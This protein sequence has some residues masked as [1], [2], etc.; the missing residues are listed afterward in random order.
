ML[1][2]RETLATSI[3]STLPA[4][5]E[6]MKRYL[7]ILVFLSFTLLLCAQP[8]TDVRTSQDIRYQGNVVTNSA[9]ET[10]V[11]WEENAGSGYQIQAQKY[12]TLGNAAFDSPVI[13]STGIY[14]VFLVETVATSDGGVV[15]LYIQDIEQQVIM[16]VQKLNSLGQAQWTGNGTFVA[17]AMSPST[18]LAPPEAKLCA[19]NLGGAF[20]V[21]WGRDDL[22][23]F[24]LHGMNY[25][26]S[27]NNIWTE[28]NLFLNPV[29]FKVNQLLLTDAGDL[30]INSAHMQGSFFRKVNNSGLSIGNDPM[31]AADA[32]I[33]AHPRQPRMQK[34]NSG[35]ILIYSSVFHEGNPLEMQLMDASGN[36]VY[37]SLKQLPVGLIDENIGELKIAA[38]S[39]GGFIL[40]CLT[41][42]NLHEASELRVQRLDAN[43]EPVW[44]SENP[45]I[46]SNSHHFKDLDMAV[47]ASDNTWLAVVRM[48]NGHRDMQVEMLKLSPD[49]IP[50]FSTQT[51]SLSTENKCSPRYSLFSNKAM[52]TWGDNNGDQISL[53][54]QIF[55]ASGEGLLTGDE[56]RISSRLYGAAYLFGVYALGSKTICLMY[57]ERGG[58]KQVYY[59]IL[60]SGMNQYLQENGQAL[61]PSDDVQHTIHVAKASPQNTLYVL[62]SKYYGDTNNMLY[63]Q[64]IDAEGAQLY[65]GSGILLGT[66]DFFGE[67]ATI[68]F[69]NESAYV[70]WAYPKLEEGIYRIAIKG[71]R[72]V[73]GAIQ[74][75]AGGLDFC[76]QPQGEASYPDAQGRYL[77]F[78]NRSIPESRYE[79][80]ALRIEPTGLI[81]PGWPVEGLSMIDA[82]L[83]GSYYYRHQAGIIEDNLYC[84]VMGVEEDTVILK[85]QKLN[86]SGLRLWGDAGLQ[87]SNNTESMQALI[88]PVINDQISIL[89]E[90]DNADIYLQKLD[91][92]GNML[93]VGDGIWMPGFNSYVQDWQLNQYA[94]GSYSYF[95][96]DGDQYS[97]Y[98]LKHVYV[99]PDGSF[100][101]VQLIQTADFYQFNTTICDNSTVICWS[102]RNDNTFDWGPILFSVSATALAEPIANADLANVPMPMV[103][104]NQNSPNPFTGT[105]RISY[106]LRDASPVK[107]QVFNIKGQLVHEL[108]QIQKAA[109]EYSWDWD[110]TD[111]NGKKCAAGIYLY[112][113]HSGRYSASR[114]MILLR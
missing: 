28:E 114:K 109:G 62:Y 112:K 25:D 8:I 105:T 83:D 68:G 66:G 42:Q 13:I 95:W 6:E 31:F 44:G 111:A 106:K 75:E 79:I 69:E 40:S 102:H 88:N 36:L 33:P 27:G 3:E 87:I 43:L 14:P 17:P 59:Q 100:Q 77:I 38:S 5:G 76:S 51:V 18:N 108:P 84:F 55:T 80:K 98:D 91:T 60:D 78:S 72:I 96:M 63:L 94:N 48:L 49:G 35:Q 30:I 104:L 46:L 11:L 21:Y 39:D 57:D 110:G 53:L 9:G 56:A 93:F 1:R 47:D 2:S 10:W 58:W 113:V 99:S 71:Q 81:S 15:L 16:K 19:N 85:A 20:L 103:I 82:G 90:K 54:R 41:S 4:K 29:T 32:V 74:W 12:S 7:G 22:H 45:L 50:A 65:P 26:A 37:S 107:I 73:A 23:G 24:V 64:E 89:Y 67:Q 86:T 61:D 34:G 92:D 97:G 70:Y 52:L 101:E